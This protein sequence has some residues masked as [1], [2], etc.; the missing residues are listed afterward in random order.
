MAYY[1][2]PRWV[3]SVSDFDWNTETQP[4]DNLKKRKNQVIFMCT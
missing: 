4:W 2:Q 1:Y 3:Y